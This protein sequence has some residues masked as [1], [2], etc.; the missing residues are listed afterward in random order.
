MPF[1][2]VPAKESAG[3]GQKRFVDVCPHFVADTQATKLIQSGEGSFH[4]PSPSP[5][6]T[7]VISFSLCDHR[8]DVAG[9]QTFPD[10]FRIIT[11]VAQHQVRT[12]ARTPSLSL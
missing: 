10:C 8:H 12:M 3:Q 9:T 2:G 1:E 4:H 6:S 11:S 5:Q 7:A